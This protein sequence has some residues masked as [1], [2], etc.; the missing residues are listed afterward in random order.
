MRYL[1]PLL[2]LLTACSSA[3][4]ATPTL[5]LP[6]ATPTLAL[7]TA[8]P[9]LAPLPSC[10]PDIPYDVLTE[11]T[12]TYKEHGEVA[13]TTETRFAG[14]G[15]HHTV[16]YD[17]EGNV[18]YQELWK[19]GVEWS[20]FDDQDWGEVTGGI[21]DRAGNQ[22]GP[23]PHESGYFAK[24]QWLYRYMGDTILDGETVRRLESVQP[25]EEAGQ[26]IQLWVNLQGYIV[27]S[28]AEIDQFGAVG[29]A[30]STTTGFGEPND[31]P[32]PA[33]ERFTPTSGM[34]GTRR[35]EVTPRGPDPTPTATPVPTPATGPCDCDGDI[36]VDAIYETVGE[37]YA[38]QVFRSIDT[39]ELTLVSAEWGI[40]KGEYEMI[41][42]I[43]ELDDGRRH[44][45]RWTTTGT[46]DAD[47]SVYPGGGQGEGDD[48]ICGEGEG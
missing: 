17:E 5:A 7:P 29:S 34:W 14:G 6:A 19:D 21:G 44:G 28:E 42:R 33:I 25:F 22:C 47:C 35:V 40:D 3:P 11:Q 10:D 20:K 4:S 48:S 43:C 45:I 8:T 18:T 39:L 27:R 12:F 23:V 30:V 31:L 38:E 32:D 36:P 41:V 24:G 16:W 2:L 46:W 37:R 1:L 15:D 13:T 26:K 9:T